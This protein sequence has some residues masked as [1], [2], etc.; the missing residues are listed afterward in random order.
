MVGTRISLV[1]GKSDTQQKLQY[2][3]S[4][5]GYQIFS[6]HATGTEALRAIRHLPS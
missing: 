6:T 2:L 3:L 5:A 4:D 1:F